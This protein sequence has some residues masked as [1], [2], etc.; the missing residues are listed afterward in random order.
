[1]A[2]Q[3][4]IR[5]RAFGVV[6]LFL[7]SLLVLIAFVAPAQQVDTG[8]H[9]VRRSS[10]FVTPKMN[11]SP[12][13]MESNAV[14]F[15]PA[16]TYTLLGCLGD[17]VV[18][19]DLDGDGHPDLAVAEWYQSCNGVFGPGALEVLLGN[20]N[21]TFQPPVTYASGGIQALSLAI[22]DLNG[23]A[24]PDLAVVNSCQTLPACSSGAATVM[25]GNGDGSLQ[26]AV[27]Y[28]SGGAIAVAIAIA[29]MD[30][31]NHPDLVVG[32]ACHPLAG[33]FACTSPGTV[34]ILLGNGDGTFQPAVSY[35]AAGDQFIASLAVGDL[36]GDGHPDVVVI[37]D[38]G[39]VS[40]LLGNGDGTFQPQVN[41]RSG[42]YEPHSLAIGDLN[43]D[44]YPDLVVVSYCQDLTNC[45]GGIVSVLLGNG[46]GTFHAPVSYS[47]GGLDALS[48]ATADVNGDGNLDVIVT[49]MVGN[50]GNGEVGVL[51]GNG[52][53]TFQAAVT[54]P[55]GGNQPESVVVSDVN[56]DSKPDVVLVNMCGNGACDGT[57]PATVGV[58]LNNTTFC[59]TTPVVTL[60][61]TPRSLWPPNG[62]MVPVTVSGKITDTSTGCTVRAAHYAVTDEY[63]EVEP[64]GP[65]ILRKGGT[66]T[67]TVLLQASRLGGDMDGRLY[68][69]YVSASNNAGKLGSQAGNV[70]VPH[71]N[72]K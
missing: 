49:N 38:A 48:V 58:L 29:D 47:S 39:L 57:I 45:N 63:G 67:F 27:S 62:K 53:G 72:G 1:M 13:A 35:A 7:E 55:S 24:K 42:G 8:W 31:D 40:V 14:S 56:G 61:T 22:G 30:G 43:G 25:L 68:S 54:F 52:D 26:P 32:N 2:H 60:S 4:K 65:V 44:G 15:L 10:G 71:D 34:G 16:V 28:A 19:G 50:G 66:Y 18:I 21:A 17:T 5:I 6:V 59:A 51:V 70:I 23:D 69:I 36:N 41:Y 64:S 11:A 46:D 33:G 9:N 3:R 20:R 12:F 37:G